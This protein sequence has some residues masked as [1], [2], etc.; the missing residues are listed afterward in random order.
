ML[1]RAYMTHGHLLADVDPLNLK[2]HYKDSP[3][4]SKKYRFAD[5]EMKYHLNPLKYGFTEADMERE[6]YFENPFNGTI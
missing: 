5:D 6:F 3:S 1:V 4:L 2:E